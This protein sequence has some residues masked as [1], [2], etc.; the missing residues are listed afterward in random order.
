MPR[1]PFKQRGH[2]LTGF[3]SPSGYDQSLPP[4][5]SQ[6]GPSHG[7]SL[8]T[9][10]TSAKER[11]FRGPTPVTCVFRVRTS[12]DALLPFVPSFPFGSGRSWDSPFRV[13]ILPGIRNL[14]RSSEPS[15]HH[16]RQRLHASNV[17]RW[18]RTSARFMTPHDRTGRLPSGPCSP[19]ESVRIATV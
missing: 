5:C 11:Y 18:T 9:A 7:V 19:W 16:P 15:W 3:H 4:C 13:L 1:S 6:H 10:I 2:P 12:R 17:N 8:P 14:F